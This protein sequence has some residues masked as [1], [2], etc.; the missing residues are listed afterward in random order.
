MITASQILKKLQAM[1]SGKD[2]KL[3]EA[4]GNSIKNA[5]GQTYTEYLDWLAK[6]SPAPKT[7]KKARKVIKKALPA[8]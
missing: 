7:S 3:A 5:K 6:P 4:A 1:V 8:K 2:N